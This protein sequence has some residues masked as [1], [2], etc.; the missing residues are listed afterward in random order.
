MLYCAE[1]QNYPNLAMISRYHRVFE[2]PLEPA[3]LGPEFELAL[4]CCR[5]NPSAAHF[6]RQQELAAS[7]LDTHKILEL[8]IRHKI[9]PLLYSNLR[10]H[11]PGTFPN[12]LMDKLAE[13][14]KRNKRRAL[15]ALQATHEL[16]RA[17]RNLRLIAM[18]GL[19]V[20]ARAYGDLAGRHVGDIDILVDPEQLDETIKILEEHQWN[21]DQPEIFSI[22]NR[23]ALLRSHH[24]WMLTKK[25][26]P[27][28][29][30][31]WRAMHNP[32]EFPI[33]DWLNL[34][35]SK[36][37]IAG[38]GGL[39]NED[40]LIYLC[41]HGAKH[42]WGRLKWLF[43]LPNILDTHDIAWPLLWLRAR[44]IGADRAVQQ[45]LLLAQKYCGMDISLEVKRGFSSSISFSH[46]QEINAFQKNPDFW[47]GQRQ[48]P[49]CLWLNRILS[50]RKIN[51]LLWYCVTLFYPNAGDYQLL[52]LPPRL[53]LFYFL[54][55]PILWG[56]RQLQIRQMRKSKSNHNNLP[57]SD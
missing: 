13:R 9:S 37:S 4:T 6:R 5:P 2:C 38:I 10:L 52:K 17:G 3:E 23:R 42:K 8:G 27:I 46:W 57:D 1:S 53:H 47:L 49:V 16:A 43:D 41:L 30:L 15:Q 31:H 12:E 24:D 29:E 48:S 28:M 34:N 19:D 7:G 32:F 40:L 26:F 18:K 33:D 51:H 54:L 45:G 25:N 20:A 56:L 36:K 22:E 50:A 55:R 11:P 39:N 44:K 35:V 14:H 21:L